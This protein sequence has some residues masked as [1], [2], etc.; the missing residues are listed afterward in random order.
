MDLR[1]SPPY[2]VVFTLSFMLIISH[3]MGES[4][5]EKQKC[6]EQ[7]T[8]LTTCLPYLGGS[9]NS[10]TSDCC[11][12]LIQSTKNNKKCICIIIKDRDDPDLGLKINITL[13]LGL[14]SLCNTPDNFSQCS[15]EF[16]QSHL[17][18]WIISFF[19][20]EFK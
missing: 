13:A 15:C 1:G 16:F 17:F 5:Q 20:K 14:P 11:S 19:I 7:L 4:A 8:D 10:P 3:T 6:A 12:G 2:M 9:A 18:V